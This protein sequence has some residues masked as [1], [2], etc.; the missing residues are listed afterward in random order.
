[1]V[2]RFENHQFHRRWGRQRV[3]VFREHFRFNRTRPWTGHRFRPEAGDWHR[4]HGSQDREWAVLEFARRLDDTAALNSISMGA[5]QIMG[6]NHTV[7]GYPDVQS[8]F[9]SFASERYQ[10]LG[11]FDFLDGEML[12][13]LR[14]QDFIR[15][16][17]LYNGR[18]QAE[19]Y[20]R[21]I[22]D[23]YEVFQALRA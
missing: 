13:A 4:F 15:F 9:E 2:I 16:A 14:R 23:H 1:V 12:A 6:F 8:M 19:E 11:L 7:I 22:R 5:P 20:G 17:S 18:G 10:L 3:D 21:R